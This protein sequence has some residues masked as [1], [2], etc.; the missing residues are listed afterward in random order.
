M[1]DP[2]KAV[3]VVYE[4]HRGEVGVRH[5]VPV[6]LYHGIA[7]PWYPEPQWLL[8][9]FDLDKNEWR[10]FSMNRIRSNFSPYPPNIELVPERKKEEAAPTEAQPQPSIQPYEG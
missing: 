10:T 4:N 8:N 6:Q 2:E 1:T 3:Y 9:G 5:F 7:L